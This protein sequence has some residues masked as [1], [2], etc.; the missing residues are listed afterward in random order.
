MKN[1]EEEM[2]YELEQC[3]KMEN[4]DKEITMNYRNTKGRPFYF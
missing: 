3:V 1:A 4:F 2:L